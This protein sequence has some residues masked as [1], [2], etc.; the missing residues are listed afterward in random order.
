MRTRLLFPLLTLFTL[1]TFIG[2]E[3]FL[4]NWQ[5]IG[6]A[7]CN[8]YTNCIN[9]TSTGGEDSECYCDCDEGWCGRRC[10]VSES[11]CNGI[12]QTYFESGSEVC[13][14]D[15]VS[16][17]I[18]P[19]LC[20]TIAIP[21][22]AKNGLSS[23]QK[24]LDISNHKANIK[25]DYFPLDEY[26]SWTYDVYDTSGMVSGQFG[27]GVT[28]LFTYL[29]T[30]FWNTE[31]LLPDTL[32]GFFT[33]TLPYLGPLLFDDPANPNQIMHREN[34]STYNDWF[35]H[36]YVDGD[37]FDF[38]GALFISDSIG[39]VTL[40]SGIF[41]NCFRLRD[42]FG[43]E[44]ILAANVGWI[45]SISNGD[46]S[47]VLNNADLACRIG[48]EVNISHV[49]C[50]GGS[51]GAF[52]LTS[53]VDLSELNFEWSGPTDIPDGT[54]P[55]N[56][57]A[58]YYFLTVS[59]ANCEATLDS[60][61]INSPPA[62][63][64]SLDSIN[65]TRCPGATDGYIGITV[66]GGTGPL[67]ISWSNGSIEEDLNG[68]PAGC[69]DV[70]VIDS[71]GCQ[72]TASFEVLDN[73]NISLVA[74]AINAS[75]NGNSDGMITV[76]V[77]GGLPPY[78]FEWNTGADTSAISDLNADTYIVTITD[79]EGCFESLEVAI[80]EP[81]PLFIELVN[82]VPIQCAGEE[83]ASI[84]IEVNG[85]SGPYNI[86]WSNGV[87]GPIIQNLS[88]GNYNVTVTDT[89]NC[90]TESNYNIPEV[91]PIEINLLDAVNVQCNGA[92][93]GYINIT[94]EGGTGNLSYNWSSGQD[95]S[96]ISNLEP[97]AYNLTV[98]DENG[99]TAASAY[100][101][102]Q[103]LAL[104]V[105]DISLQPISCNGGNNGAIAIDVVGGIPPYQYI[106]NDEMGGSSIQDLTSGNYI[107]QIVDGNN[108]VFNTN[109]ILSEP[110]PIV[111]EA[112]EIIDVD[113]NGQNTGAIETFVQG[114]TA[115]YQYDWSNNSDMQ[116][117]ESAEAGGY[118][119]IITDNNNC[120]AQESFT[121]SEPE[122]LEVVLNQIEEPLCAGD[123][124][125]G[126]SIEV[127]GGS[128]PYQ[129]DWDNGAT[130]NTIS[131]LDAGIYVAQVLDNNNC[132][133]ELEIEIQEPDPLIIALSATSSP[134]DSMSGEATVQIVGGTPP[135]TILWDDELMQTSSTATNLSP[136]VYEV[137]VTDMNACEIRDSVV[138]EMTTSIL[139]EDL[140][141]I[142]IF[143]NPASHTLHVNIPTKKVFSYSILDIKGRIL[144]TSKGQFEGTKIDVMNLNEGI[145]LL[146]INVDQRAHLVRFYKSRY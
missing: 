104:T 24:E 19:P 116:D 15:C 38:D 96:E 82:L 90:I 54:N 47:M 137:V 99:C 134:I 114:G 44:Y 109:F 74:T 98:T 62:I 88:T 48:L 1:I 127:T 46:T 112:I 23:I 10:G 50:E 144:S 139:E 136:G 12:L 37:T 75:C 121:V 81:D 142:Q 52:E 34:D 131:G 92:A 145:Y 95:T 102:F 35:R 41:E 110:D 120:T 30:Q 26:N 87:S 128:P 32:T 73:D 65:H 3:S 86:I 5:D 22:T 59:N 27:F 111:I 68:L 29:D 89:N 78:T 51:D 17:F 70:I 25:F 64:I 28:N 94:A 117:L 79:D 119:L 7:L 105:S 129:I 123:M 57:S 58:G 91:L 60:L 138:V 130:G 84:A 140:A 132:K 16:P 63:I 21:L 4:A 141:P 106:W 126:A 118:S 69:Y 53:N 31:I 39:T 83:S 42:T 101:I 108:C 135:Y 146:M 11:N 33:D 72:S 66:S 71:I 103:P 93:N 49:T 125:G 80:T 107:L 43:L 56:L 67:M 100:Q 76:Q 133:S 14:C 143:P 55:V 18:N 45:A 40:S 77:S 9:G 2:C 8:N 85:G 115:P 36:S 20:N 6:E 122:E 61:P 113:C 124:T 97:G 13:F